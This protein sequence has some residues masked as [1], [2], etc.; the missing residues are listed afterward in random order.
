[1]ARLEPTAI[2]PF[3]NV[4]SSK[5]D[6]TYS[7]HSLE[8]LLNPSYR[9]EPEAFWLLSQLRGDDAND[10]MALAWGRRWKPIPTWGRDGWDLGSWPYVVVYHRTTDNAWQLAENAEGD[11][12]VYSYGS[13]ELRDA[14]T[15]CLAFSYWKQGQRGWVAGIDS[16]DF[17]P[18]D[19][20][21]PFSWARLEG[22]HEGR[23]LGQLRP[24]LLIESDAQP[25]KGP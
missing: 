20:R 24:A 13:R 21:G 2:S 22:S 19:L 4:A 17:A 18:D 8:A 10:G 14:A 9:I 5:I 11:V 25:V 6:P 1:M 15:D 23:A 12:T 7:M 16:V 3:E